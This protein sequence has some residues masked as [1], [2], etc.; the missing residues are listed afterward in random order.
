MMCGDS[1]NDVPGFARLVQD[2]RPDE[3][4][5]PFDFVVDSL[6]D[7]VKEP[8]PLCWSGRQLQFRRDVGCYESRLH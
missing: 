3:G 5:W 4:V 2:V 6:A 7:I 1:M 8:G